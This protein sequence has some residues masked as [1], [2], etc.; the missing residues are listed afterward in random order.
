MSIGSSVS[1]A[2]GVDNET[3][4][5]ATNAVLTAIQSTRRTTNRRNGS[6]RAAIDRRTK[7]TWNPMITAC[8]STVVTNTQIKL[9]SRGSVERCSDASHLVTLRHRDELTPALF[10]VSFQAH[11]KPP[12]W[13]V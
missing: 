7:I 3:T 8:V 4:A 10:V 5:H 11:L 6:I 12:P 9:R 2:D 13:L 1:S